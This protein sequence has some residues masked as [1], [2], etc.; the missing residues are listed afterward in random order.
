MVLV[1]EHRLH[2]MSSVHNL[3]AFCLVLRRDQEAL[4]GSRGHRPGNVLTPQL[5]V[6]AL[7]QGA[8]GFGGHFVTVR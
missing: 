7:L 4:R 2:C 6:A 5:M 1:L 3:E 8:G